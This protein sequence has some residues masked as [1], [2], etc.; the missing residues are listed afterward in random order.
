MTSRE[1]LKCFLLAAV[2]IVHT[3]TAFSTTK[4]FGTPKPK[5]KIVANDNVAEQTTRSLFGV[6]SHL[7]NPELYSPPW[8]DMCHVNEDGILVAAKDIVRGDIVS[9]YPVHSIGLR[10]LGKKQG[11]R[12]NQRQS[13]YLVF[14]SE[15]DGDF[16]GSSR[17]TTKY[18][19]DFP[20]M[21]NRP[22]L[23]GQS[24]FLDVNPDR[25]LVQGW[26]GHLCKKGDSQ[27]ANCAAI[28]IN[29][30]SPLCVVVATRDILMGEMLTRDIA[31]NEGEVLVKKQ[32]TKS[33]EMAFKKYEAQIAELRGFTDMVYANKEVNSLEE[34]GNGQEEV[35]RDQALKFKKINMDYPGLKELHK[36]PDIYA[37]DKF[38]TA[39]ECNRIIAKCKPKMAPCVTKD[40]LTGSV[41]PNSSRTST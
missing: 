41:G 24:L 13:D 38:L 2:L 23:R 25:K 32:I 10:G 35:Q 4:G 33:G 5:Q 15:K 40:P 36:D 7:Q 9:F 11:K 31:T 39:D 19:I 12:K 1:H 30:V 29:E 37:V 18:C 16:F 26:L 28:P 8:S 6:C 17:R 3:G 20:A 21:T 27:N 14:D 34:K 22:E